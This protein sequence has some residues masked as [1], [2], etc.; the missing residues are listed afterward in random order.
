MVADGIDAATPFA[1]ELSG[2]AVRLRA[3][4]CDTCAGSAALSSLMEHPC[5]KCGQSVEEGTPFCLHCSAPQI[6]VAIAEPPT[7]PS[8]DAATMEQ[9]SSALPAS[10]TPPGAVLPMRWSQA[11]RPCALAALVAAV[12]MALHLYPFV[13]LISMGF[14]AVAF[15]RQRRP[16]T[17]IRAQ[18]GAKLGALSAVLWFGAASIIGAL[19]VILLH[20]GEEVR[21]YLISM[22]QQSASQTSDPQRLAILER[23]KTPD[24][25]LFLLCFLLIFSFLTVIILAALGGALG[26]AIFGGKDKTQ[27]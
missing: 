23:F 27:P 13:A 14:L 1:S 20:K 6:R 19:L 5:H 16:G 7:V 22:I 8:A 17:V 4:P 24:G 25:L 12:L 11:L 2:M 3:P 26:G 18:A 10:D 15:Y 9:V 21:N